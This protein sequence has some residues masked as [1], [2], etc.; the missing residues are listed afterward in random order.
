MVFRY[1][2]GFRD[3]P[4]VVPCGQC[5]GCRLDWAG[6]WA[7]RCEKEA[8][9]HEA[10][11]FITL[12]YNDES[13]PISIDPRG[14]VV[15][16][17]FQLFMKRLRKQHGDKIRFFASGEYGDLNQRPHYHAI[18]FGCAFDDLVPWKGGRFPLYTSNK[19]ATL[20]G[21]G[22]V[23]VGGVSYQSSSY[24]ARYVLKKLRGLAEVSAYTQREAPFIL[25]SRRP[26]IGSA[27]FDQFHTDVY[28]DGRLHVGEGKIRRAPRYFDDKFKVLDPKA[29]LK[30]KAKRKAYAK[31]NASLPVQLYT[32]Q[33]ITKS[34]LNLLSRPL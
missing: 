14:T 22:F 2:E 34:R 15:K 10:N 4:T 23:T 3:L 16:R 9:L 6:D 29:H 12:T 28:P 26:G 25:M 8:K 21:Q 33:E 24:V 5:L 32:K 13:L 31:A 30:M 19:L 1:R 27:W 18:L 20:W 17:D 7:A 11:S